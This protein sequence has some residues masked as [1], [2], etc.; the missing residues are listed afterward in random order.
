MSMHA[1]ALSSPRLQRVLAVLREGRRMTTRSIIRKA[2]VAAVNAIIAELRCH[3]AE[4]VCEQEVV[5]GRR[6]WFYTMVKEPAGG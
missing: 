4:I 1:A 5:G 6:R 2:Q 3:G